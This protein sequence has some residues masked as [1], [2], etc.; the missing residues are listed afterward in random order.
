MS[1]GM[2]AEVRMVV[3]S[4]GE[5]SKLEAAFAEVNLASTRLGSASDRPRSIFMWREGAIVV[6]V[7]KERLPAS[8][9]C[10]TDHVRLQ[11]STS[12]FSVASFSQCINVS[13]HLI[14][15][16]PYR[17]ARDD[18]HCAAVLCSNW[19]C[20]PYGGGLATLEE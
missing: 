1:T 10:R 18:D 19:Q 3:T 9:R 20:T 4:V 16:F 8:E 13:S 12:S 5:N 2:H 14:Q 17:F 7:R 11:L 6:E 15:E